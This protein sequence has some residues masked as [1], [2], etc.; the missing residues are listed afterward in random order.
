MRHPKF[1]YRYQFHVLSSMTVVSIQ[2]VIATKIMQYRNDLQVKTRQDKKT[3]NKDITK[4]TINARTY[5][6]RT[7]CQMLNQFGPPDKNHLTAMILLILSIAHLRSCHM[8]GLVSLLLLCVIAAYN[9]PF[10]V[11]ISFGIRSFGH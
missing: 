8:F 5:H 1:D 3:L 10:D 7:G 2:K 4:N 11:E 9:N 6:Y